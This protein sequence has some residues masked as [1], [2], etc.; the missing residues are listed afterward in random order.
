MIMIIIVFSKVLKSKLSQF[1]S[2]KWQ[3]RQIVLQ[4]AAATKEALRQSLAL[5]ITLGNRAF[6]FCYGILIIT[7]F[8]FWMFYAMNCYGSIEI[9]FWFKTTK[10]PKRCGSLKET[11]SR[12]LLPCPIGI[13]KYFSY[14][15]TSC[16]GGNKIL[17]TYS[18]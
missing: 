12:S 16:N 18:T 17:N 2:L 11:P 7:C 13:T 14:S 5:V 15:Y 8:P 9:K 4:L 10:Y 3:Q 1:S 6:S